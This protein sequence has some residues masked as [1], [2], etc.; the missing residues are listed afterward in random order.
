[1]TKA[2]PD[3]WDAT[4]ANNT[5]IGGINI[6]EG[7]PAAGVN[8]AFREMMAQLKTYFTAKFALYLPLAGGTMTGAIL[9]MS[10]GSTVKD[11]AGT[12]RYVGYRNIPLRAASAQQTLVLTDAGAGI[13]ITTGGIIIPLNATVAFAVGDIIAIYNNSASTQQITIT[14]T[15]TLR[16]GGTTS[17]GARTLAVRGLATLL[18]VDTDEWIAK[19]DVT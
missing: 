17:T 9:G 4:A 10:T 5:D 14:A 1:M 16:L 8:N 12:G 19:G 13:S 2:T 6:A 7:C 3:D 11:G 15:G 18:K